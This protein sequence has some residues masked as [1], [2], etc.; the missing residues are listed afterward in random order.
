MAQ[1]DH[2]EL[3][4]AIVGMAGRFP[5]APSVD[6]LWRAL[7]DG[8]EGIRDLTEEE[9]RRGGIGAPAHGRLRRR[10][11]RDVPAPPRARE[12]ARRPRRRRVPGLAREPAR[13]PRD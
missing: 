12:P 5:G 9:L 8:V 10:K 4:I 1:D 3:G 6:A 13:L 2:I 7:R 11:P